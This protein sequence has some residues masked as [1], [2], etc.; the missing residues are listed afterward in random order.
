MVIFTCQLNFEVEVCAKIFFL[1]LVKIMAAE[2]LYKPKVY[3]VQFDGA[4]GFLAFSI[5][6]LHLHFV[7]IKVPSTL[8]NFTLHSFFVASAFL[9]TSI[10]LRD[11]EKTNSFS[12]FFK[13]FYIKRILRIFPV[14]FGY[15]LGVLFFAVLF[16]KIFHHDFAG[17]LTEV[18]HYWFL[19]FSFTYNFRDFFSIFSYNDA[20]ISSNMFPHLWSISLEE[21]FYIIIPFLI[22]YLSR[23]TL[24]KVC[25]T[26]I[27]VFPI[28]R[29]IGYFYLQEHTMNL[30]NGY[31]LMGFAMIR[32]SLF[33]FDAFFY[34]IL[35]ALY[36]RIELKK[37]R[38]V[39]YGSIIAMI[40]HDI[41]SLYIIQQ[42]FGIPFYEMI[43]RYDIF[44]RSG[45]AMYIDVILNIGCFA[46]WYLIFYVNDEFP[47]LHNKRLVEYGKVS[48]GS[49]VYQYI[50]IYLT[51]LLLYE[52]LKPIL[53]LFATELI[54]TILYLFALLQFSK[55]SYYKY[56]LYFINLKDKLIAKIKKA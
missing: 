26:I 25:F 30:E 10:L 6:I 20:Q 47:L 28:F 12:Y 49:Y 16:K 44:A 18:K 43:S 17:V 33:Q 56:E 19:M 51:Y 29:I 1:S 11:K 27:L 23:E 38:F 2:E 21:Q 53:P 55:L 41:V 35:M 8:A 37:I 22:F 14:Y 5:L 48:Y 3:Y 34:G 36:P 13:Q 7:Y 15:I 31:Y 46:F 50:F 24:K 39:F 52:S 32:N 40:I 4:R 45:S 42:K 9:I 54:C